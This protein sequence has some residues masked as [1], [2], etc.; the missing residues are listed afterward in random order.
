M[1][2]VTFQAQ[3]IKNHLEYTHCHR[4]AEGKLRWEL[5]KWISKGQKVWQE[6]WSFFLICCLIELCQKSWPE[7]SVGDMSM[8]LKTSI[9][10]V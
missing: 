9:S 3:E 10:K 8:L 7:I 4:K 5:E 1:Q 2:E 6:S